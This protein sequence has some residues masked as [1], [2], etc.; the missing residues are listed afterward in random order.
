MSMTRSNVNHGK[1][2][3]MK[4]VARVAGVALGTVSNVLN[5]PELVSEATKAR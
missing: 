4:D 3:S 2:V 1:S 5:N